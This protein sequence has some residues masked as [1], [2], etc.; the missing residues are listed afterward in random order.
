V[1]DGRHTIALATWLAPACLLRF[2]R[3]E[4]LL[5]GLAMAYVALVVMRGMAFRGMTPIPGIVYYVVLLISAAFALL[6]YL[7][8]RLATH[9][10]TGLASTFIF[11][12]ALVA[13]QF[14]YSHG[15]QGTWGATA[16]TQ[17]C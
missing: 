8:D 15:P 14:V 2:V 7:A 3:G 13:A 5:R 11:P 16:Y 1:A 12:C 17:T 10:L 4:R 6:P 9:K